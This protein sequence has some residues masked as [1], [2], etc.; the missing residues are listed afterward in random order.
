MNWTRIKGHWKELE[1]RV[2]AKWGALTDD[3]LVATRSSASP[4][5]APV[6][7]AE[8]KAPISEDPLNWP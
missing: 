8:S 2:R 5:T 6:K 3:D 7:P 1:C 4:S